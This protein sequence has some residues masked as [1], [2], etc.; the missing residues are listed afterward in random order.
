VGL[1]I[2]TV[3]SSVANPG[4]SGTNT[5]VTN[6]GDSFT[7]RTFQQGTQAFISMVSRTHSASGFAR[8]VSPLMHDAVDGM[9]WYTSETPS[10]HFMPPMVGQPIQPGDTLTV[11]VSGNTTSSAI[12]GYSN[13]YQNLSG[14]SANLYQWGD[15]SGNIKS[16]KPTTV[17]V[18]AS[19]TVGTWKD[20]LITATEN[21]LHASSFYA[22][23]GFLSD[24]AIGLVGVKGSA[25]ANFRV[26]GPGNTAT[27]LTDY[28]FV[29]LA[30]YHGVPY[31]P[32][33]NGE[34]RTSVYVSVADAAASTA[35]NITLVLAELSGS[36]WVR[37]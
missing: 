30:N 13:Y 20:T 23:L 3:L 14:A 6:S 7:V 5:S 33:F 27:T 8:I 36:N 29:D 35:A 21:L 24:T 37:Q 19:G 26:C 10:I 17:A 2:D 15:I 4:A 16:I 31:I 34:D 11:S 32:V 28:F 18:T 12:V 22:V 9:T 1:A 25:T